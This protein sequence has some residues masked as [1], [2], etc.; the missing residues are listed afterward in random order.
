MSHRQITNRDDDDGDVFHACVHDDDSI[1]HDWN[2]FLI[3][4]LK[5]GWFGWKNI[6]QKYPIQDMNI[7]E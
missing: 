2:A 5:W 4:H 3:I 7:Y 6:S 1:H